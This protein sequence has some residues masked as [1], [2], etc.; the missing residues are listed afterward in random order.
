MKIKKRSI[1]VLGVHVDV[2]SRV[3][4][5]ITNGYHCLSLWVNTYI[6]IFLV[7]KVKKKKDSIWAR[8]HARPISEIH[9]DTFTLTFFVDTNQTTDLS[10]SFLTLNIDVADVL[11]TPPLPCFH[12]PAPL[13]S[14]SENVFG[15][16]VG[17]ILGHAI[18]TGSAVI[19]GRLLAA[20]ISVRHVT[21]LGGIIFIIFAFVA[22]G[23]GPEKEE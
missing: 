8:L 11:P 10:G 19:G 16:I 14:F 7:K 12:P 4:R 22:I 5:P 15:V 3:G 1:L 20:K 17:G 18:C 21:L 2:F 23:V 13:S 9:S 6:I